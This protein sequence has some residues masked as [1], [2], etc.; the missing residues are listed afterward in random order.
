MAR[1]ETWEN[2]SSDPLA[3]ASFAVQAC[4][5]GDNRPDQSSAWPEPAWCTGCKNGLRFSQVCSIAC[6]SFTCGCDVS[7]VIIYIARQAPSTCRPAHVDHFAC[8]VMPS[9]CQRQQQHPMISCGHVRPCQ[10]TAMPCHTM[11]TCVRTHTRALPPLACLLVFTD[12]IL[13]TVA[14]RAKHC[15]STCL[16]RCSRSQRISL[17]VLDEKSLVLHASKALLDAISRAT[18]DPADP[19]L[20]LFADVQGFGGFAPGVTLPTFTVGPGCQPAAGCRIKLCRGNCVSGNALEKILQGRFRFRQQKATGCAAGTV[21]PVDHRHCVRR[22]CHFSCSV[23]HD[24]ATPCHTMTCHATP[25]FNMPCHATPCHATLCHAMSCHPIPCH[26]MPC[27]AMPHA[28]VHAHMHARVHACV[29]VCACVR[30]HVHVHVC[31]GAGKACLASNHPVRACTFCKAT[32]MDDKPGHLATLVVAARDPTS[33]RWTEKTGAAKLSC[34]TKPGSNRAAP[35]KVGSARNGALCAKSHVILP[36]DLDPCLPHSQTHLPILH[37]FF[38]L[39]G[40]CFRQ[41]SSL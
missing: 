20:S 38:I 8:T 17:P 13:K 23:S 3:T 12:D 30:V 35:A 21:D 24:H 26:A 32:F 37:A 36:T 5:W 7:D 11:H 14:T 19:F 10:T 15:N 25:H 28:L 40:T 29:C 6:N 34:F 2:E 1:L 22:H 18:V 9:P 4:A 31:M 39:R 16:L 33:G 41:E 27:H